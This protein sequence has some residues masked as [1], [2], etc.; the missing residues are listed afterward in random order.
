MPWD[1]C[2]C[3]HATINLY[4]TTVTREEIQLKLSCPG[5]GILFDFI[6]LIGKNCTQKEQTYKYI[7]HYV[8]TC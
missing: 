2:C 3:P 5:K 8:E 6:D 7:Y 4:Y 1:S